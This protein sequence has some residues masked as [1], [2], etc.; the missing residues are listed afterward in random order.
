MR[1]II[2]RLFG[3]AVL[4]FEALTLLDT[5]NRVVTGR[6]PLTARVIAGNSVATAGALLVGVG[7]LFLRKW[8]ALF[9]SVASLWVGS[10]LVIGSI[11]YV[12]FPWQ[13]ANFFLALFFVAPSGVTYLFWQ[14][15]SRKG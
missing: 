15:L 10:W 2:F 12:P 11:L 4:L 7:L 9:F 6:L 5:A 13:L 8:A 14:D 1:G 3:V